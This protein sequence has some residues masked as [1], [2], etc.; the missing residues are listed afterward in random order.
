MS[1]VN[2]FVASEAYIHVENKQLVLSG[3]KQ[4]SFPLED[5]NSVIVE[6]RNTQ[7]SVCALTE[8]AAAGGVVFWCDEKH[9][10]TTVTLPSSTFYR[11]LKAIRAQ[12]GAS[13][14]LIKQLWQKVVKQKI[15]N[16]AECL[17]LCGKPEYERVAEIGKRVLSGDSENREAEAAAVYFKALFGKDFVRSADCNIN[18]A[19]NYGYAVMRGLVARTIVCHG[20]EPSLG[21]FHCNELNPFNLADDLMEPL[22]PVVDLFAFTYPP[23][24]VI[25]SVYKKEICNLMNADVLSGGERHSVTH[26]VERMISSFAKS[27][28]S[29]EA[30]L[31]LPQLLPL[32]MHEYE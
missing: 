13:K 30:D 17:K 32:F 24:Q 20:F 10:P 18:F 4:M 31:Q 26:S 22:R 1:Y 21:I 9:L 19:L 6:N 11:K 25:Q 23:I 14:P 5:I 28:Y 2:V 7:V 8:I 3:A 27:L 15:A 12:T 16:Q 29:G